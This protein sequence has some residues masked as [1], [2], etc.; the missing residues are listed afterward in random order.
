MNWGAALI[1]AGD[2]I[3][4]DAAVPEAP[5]LDPIV[6]GDGK[7]S[8]HWTFGSNR[9]SEVT[10]VEV[11]LD[12]GAWT[13]LATASRD[14][15][16][17]ELVNDVEVSARVR[18]VNG[19]GPSDPS[20]ARLGTP[21]IDEEEEEDPLGII[22]A[23]NPRSILDANRE[24]EFRELGDLGSADLND[25]EDWSGTFAKS[26]EKDPDSVDFAAPN[27][28]KADGQWGIDF[29]TETLPRSVFQTPENA[30]EY[31][32]GGASWAASVVKI[33]TDP[34]PA[35]D[36]S[37]LKLEDLDSW[38]SLWLGSSPAEGVYWEMWGEDPPDPYTLS[39]LYTDPIA[40][41]NWMR[42]VLRHDG[43]NLYALVNGVEIGPIPCNPITADPLENKLYLFMQ[44]SRGGASRLRHLTLGRSVIS[45]ADS[46]AIDAALAAMYP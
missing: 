42:V 6:A 28:N 29:Q 43:T 31:I 2:R 37:F 21:H 9:G 11:S 10:D 1:A 33:K 17:E 27:L 13:S 12:E 45:A 15:D 44:P 20:N 36:G 3:P 4:G 16:V 39:V 18:A 34:A 35:I 46:L 14:A 19:V 7:I 24:A 40:A 32:A 41:G 38:W 26:W 30:N 23:L 8:L 5:L 22:L 25:A